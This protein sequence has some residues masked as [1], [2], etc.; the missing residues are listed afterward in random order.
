MVALLV[1]LAAAL[2]C[3]AGFVACEIQA[4]DPSDPTVRGPSSSVERSTR[5]SSD[6]PSQ[7]MTTA[8][9][10]ST[11]LDGETTT[12]WAPVV[13]DAGAA[14]RRTEEAA[15]DRFPSSTAG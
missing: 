15:L 12:S 3:A 4:Q 1:L 11:V 2:V 14:F 7:A 13:D 6:S 5:R 9:R 8:L 10:T